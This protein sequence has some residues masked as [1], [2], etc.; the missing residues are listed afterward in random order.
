[1][2]SLFAALLLVV[3]ST[4]AHAYKSTEPEICKLQ[5]D[6]GDN[7]KPQ[8]TA[9]DID[10]KKVK[11]LSAY[12]L[13]LVNAYLMDYGYTTKPAS[14]KEI[15]ELF[16]TGE[17]SYNDLAIVIR[18]SVATGVTHIEVK[19]WPGDNPVGAFF[20]VNGKMIGHND[21][22]SISYFDA[23]GERVYCSF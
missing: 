1:M 8:F 12:Y 20:D 6:E 7:D 11:S 16:T 17:E 15:Q 19:S 23:K 9:Q 3:V 5:T 21:D 2:K 10:V 4:Q 14:L 13:K 22:D 18:T